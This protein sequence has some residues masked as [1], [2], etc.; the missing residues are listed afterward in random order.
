[1]FVAGFTGHYSRILLHQKSLNDAILFLELSDQ[2][3]D[4]LLHEINFFAF[5]GVVALDAEHLLHQDVR[6][7]IRRLV[8]SRRRWRR[9]VC[10]RMVILQRNKSNKNEQ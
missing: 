9:R 3:V 6:L 7:P 4:V 2:Y 1:M 5:F 8:K 10:R